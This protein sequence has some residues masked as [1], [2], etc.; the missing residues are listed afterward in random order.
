MKDAVERDFRRLDEMLDKLRI[1]EIDDE[2]KKIYEQVLDGRTFKI[3][4]K[5][6]AKGF[7][8]A[9]GGV[10]STG[11]EAHVFYADGNF[12]GKDVPLA[13]KIYKIETSEFKKMD[14]YIFGDRRFD[15]LRVSPK[16]KIFLWAEKEFRNLQRA[17]EANVSVPKP[18]VQ[19]K[20]V[21]LMQFIGENELPAPLL[22]DVAKDIED[23]ER[24]F[25]EILENI[26]R[27]YKKAELVH[28]DLSEYNILL[29]DKVYFID[30]GQAVLKD[31]PKAKFY[32]KRDL[33]NVVRFFEKFGIKADVEEIF[34]DV[35]EGEED[36]NRD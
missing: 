3:L 11:K 18:Y 22:I 21:I 13:V 14:E 8:K 34:N 25:E 19:M 4:Y 17:Y 31:H 32:L 7:I 16:D 9:M 6:S 35:T 24:I 20:N 26:K 27:L 10:V 1:K 15:F 5:L 12:D 29:Y 36:E 28:A 33:K 2:E 23:A 30:M